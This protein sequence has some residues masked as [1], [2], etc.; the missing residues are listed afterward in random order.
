MR[1][2][3]FPL[4]LIA[5]TLPAA[6]FAGFT[7]PSIDGGTIDLDGFKGRPVL[8]V[9]TASL[10]GFAPQFDDLQSLHDDYAARGLV[11]LAVPSDDFR[12]EL[13]SAAEVKEFCAV[14]FDL[15]IPMT[16]ITPVLGDQAHPFYKWLAETEGFT[17]GWNFNKVLLDGEGEVVAT[18]GS[19]M[20]PTAAPVVDRIE[21]LLP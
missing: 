13:A 21:A 15:T 11:V 12:Q 9:N 3:L 6:A 8:V 7:F 19:V 18:W 16:D 2:P 10:C 14:N 1:A 5:A 17:P 4:A 20:R